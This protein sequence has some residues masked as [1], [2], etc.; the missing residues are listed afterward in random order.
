MSLNAIDRRIR[1]NQ[2][3][4]F[5]LLAS[6]CLFS[7]IAYVELTKEPTPAW[8]ARH[9]SA[10][11]NIKADSIVATDD[12]TPQRSNDTPSSPSLATAVPEPASLLLMLPAAF[13]L[14]RRTRRH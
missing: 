6:T 9:M 7:L 14:A 10:G 12:S 2:G 4:S 1:R 11:E 3:T 8:H 5:V 13:L